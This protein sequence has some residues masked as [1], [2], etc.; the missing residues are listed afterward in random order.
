MG[1]VPGSHQRR[2]ADLIARTILQ[3]QELPIGILTA[4]VGTPFL[5]HLIRRFQPAT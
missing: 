5:L 3:P 2:P 4:L 1:R